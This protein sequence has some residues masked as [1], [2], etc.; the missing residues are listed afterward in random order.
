MWFVLSLFNYYFYRFLFIYICL[1]VFPESVWDGCERLYTAGSPR[2]TAGTA[3]N[4]DR[5]LAHD[6]RCAGQFFR[7][8]CVCVCVCVWVFV[9]MFLWVYAC[10]YTPGSIWKHVYTLFAHTSLFRHCWHKWV[11]HRYMLCLYRFWWKMAHQLA[12]HWL[13][14]H[15][16][17]CF[18]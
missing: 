4:G 12:S 15:G 9:A 1:M 10:L 11:A 17:I 5:S 7:V 18:R 6:F 8:V 14:K 16:I 3:G 2:A 13:T